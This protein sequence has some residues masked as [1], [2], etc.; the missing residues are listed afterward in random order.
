[1]GDISQ[2]TVEVRVSVDGKRAIFSLDYDGEVQSTI[3]SKYFK[4]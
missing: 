3:S 4:K 1:M 2:T